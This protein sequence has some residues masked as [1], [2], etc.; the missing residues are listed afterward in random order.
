MSIQP[1]KWKDV[2]RMVA[3]LLN[4]QV[5][6]GDEPLY[7]GGNLIVWWN[8]AQRHLST[9]KPLQT[10]FHYKDIGREV[11]EP[12]NMYRPVRALVPRY[13]RIERL[14]LEEALNGDVTGFY[15]FDNKVTFTGRFPADD[16]YLYYEAYYPDV[17]DGDSKV[18]VPKWALEACS[19]YTAMLVITS[20]AVK[21]ARY[22]KFLSRIDAGN[23]TQNPFI[24]VAEWLEKRFYQIVNA[25]SDD[26]IDFVG[27]F[28]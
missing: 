8:Q 3:A 28:G 6:E 4:D 17:V 13:G 15:T 27:D 16:F 7:D 22:R 23:P 21:D 2:E 9:I 14:T 10:I 20:E 18:L 5:E 19:M 12:D 26:D 1:S 11:D 25:H 24:L